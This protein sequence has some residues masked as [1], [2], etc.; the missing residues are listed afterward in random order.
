MGGL[1]A[2]HPHFDGR[3]P[4]GKQHAAPGRFPKGIFVFP[5]RRAER[6][7]SV[8]PPLTL[9]PPVR[10]YFTRTRRLPRI[11]LFEARTGQETLY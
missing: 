7:V 2:A 5:G 8:F 10:T 1:S 4:A 9:P 6:D 3:I 11:L